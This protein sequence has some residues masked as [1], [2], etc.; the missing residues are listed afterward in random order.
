MAAIPLPSIAALI[1]AFNEEPVISGTISALFDAGMSAVHIYVVD[2]RST[3]RTAEIARS[4]G[5]NVFTVPENGG[6]ARAQVQAIEHFGLLDTYDFLV[7]LDGDTKVTKNFFSALVDAAFANAGVGLFVG[8]VQSA[9]ND[10]LFS[11]SRAFDYT[12]GQDLGKQAQSNFNMIFVSPGCASMYWTKALKE[13][14]IDHLTLAEDMDLTIQAHKKGFKV[15]YVPNAVVVTQDPSTLQ[16]YHKQSLRWYRGFW[17]VVKKHKVFGWSPKQRV[18]IYMW[19]MV[20]DAFIFNR[21]FWLITTL[22]VNPAILPMVV[23]GDLVITGCIASYCA[24]RTKRLDVL[25]KFPIYYWLS[26]LNV[27]TFTRAFIEIVVL[28][29]DILAWNKVKRYTFET[30]TA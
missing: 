23:A 27:Y 9:N 20:L 26:F 1:P 7:F 11:A 29:K 4:M 21:I 10:H 15:V 3:D 14:Q 28:R 17:Q 6:K 2:D 25:Y 13:L 16:D 24:Y 30:Q 19:L 22:L 5:V 12:F 8:H 18:D